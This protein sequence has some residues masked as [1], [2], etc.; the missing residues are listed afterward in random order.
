MENQEQV[1]E[2]QKEGAVATELRDKGDVYQAIS[3]GLYL[4]VFRTDRMT[5]ERPGGV[6]VFKFY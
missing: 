4:S 5:V 3:E 2:E 1:Q 6:I